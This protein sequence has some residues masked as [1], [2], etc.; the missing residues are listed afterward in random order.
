M[1]ET[2]RDA[3]SFFAALAEIAEDLRQDLVEMPD[4][5]RS[6]H[7]SRLVLES[8]MVFG[9][10]PDAEQPEETGAQVIKGDDVLPPLAGFLMPED[11]TITAIPC[12][13]IEQAL[14]AR[15]AWMLY[16][17]TE[18][19]TATEETASAAARATSA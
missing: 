14:A 7:V 3:R 18:E 11:V 10:W 15:D 12:V 19:R 8:T 5:E 4:Q 1:S 13:G 2:W 6:R 17:E 9:V 16:E